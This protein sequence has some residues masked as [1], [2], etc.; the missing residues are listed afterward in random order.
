MFTVNTS[1]TQTFT[2]TVHILTK[3][4][5]FDFTM[6]QQDATKLKLLQAGTTSLGNSCEY[7]GFISVF[8]FYLS[9][10]PLFCQYSI[11]CAGSMQ[12]GD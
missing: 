10:I 5:T 3:C 9:H 11:L 2:F 1:L 4:R 12:H 6:N 8:Y 7:H